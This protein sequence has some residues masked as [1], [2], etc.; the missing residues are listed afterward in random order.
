MPDKPVARLPL[1]AG[2]ALQQG[3]I[4][5]VTDR[6]GRLTWWNDEAA[7]AFGLGAEDALGMPF[8]VVCGG[9]TG[10]RPVDIDAVLDGRDFA[11]GIECSRRDGERM[12]LYAFATAGR[13]ERGEVAGVVFIARDVTGYWRAEEVLRTSEEKYRRLFEGSSDIVLV[14]DTTGRIEDANLAAIH[15]IGYTADEL[16]SLSLFEIVAPAGRRAAELALTQMRQRGS[17]MSVLTVLTRTGKNVTLETSTSI[18]RVGASQKV[19]VIGRD[20]T[21]RQLA[22]QRV[23][24]SEHKYRRIFEAS[25]DAIMLATFEMR[26]V[27]CNDRACEMFGRTQPELLALSI[28]DLVAHGQQDWL[29]LLNERLVRTGQYRGDVSMLGQQGPGG[30]VELTVDMTASLLDL[31]DGPVVL[32]VGHD[33]SERRRA[34]AALRESEARYRTLRDNVPIGLFRTT[35]DGRFISI[36]PA[37]VRIAGYRSEAEML[38]V[39]V[40]D[41]YADPAE[42]DRLLDRLARDGRVVDAQVRMRRPDGTVYDAQLNVEVTHSPDGAVQYFDGAIQDITE[43]KRIAAE[44]VD[45]EARLRLLLEQLPTVLWTVDENLV[46][47]TSMGAG[48]AKLGQAPGEVVGMTLYEYFGTD[49]PEFQPIAAHRQVLNGGSARY[50]L[51]WNGETFDTVLEPLRDTGGA[52]VGVIGLATDVTEERR[53]EAE[54][55]ASE[56]RYR[57][58]FES[59]TDSVAIAEVDGRV[60]DA[61]PACIKTYGYTAEEVRQMNLVDVVAPEMR[62]VAVRAMADLATGKP[63]S[64]TIP[65]VRKDGSRLTVDTLAFVGTVGG[66]RRIFSFTR[67]VSARIAAEAARHASEVRYRSLAENS[68][69][70][71]YIVDRGGVVR[72]CNSAG[73]AALGRP[74]EALVGRKVSELFP[75]T[76]AERQAGSLRKVFETGEPQHV[77]GPPRYDDREVWLSTWLVGL[78]DAAGNVTEV[79]GVSRDLTERKRAEDELRESEARYRAI[80]ETTAAAT[81]II[82]ADTTISLVNQEFTR[83]FGYAGEEVR[84]RSWTEFVAKED[85]ERLRS[86][87]ELR[88]SEDPVTAPRTYEARLVDKQGAVRQCLLTV[89]MVAGTGRSVA[90]ILDI[91]ERKRVEADLLDSE[92]RFRNLFQSVPVGLYRTTPDGRIL[93]A[94]PALV[95]MLG[96]DSWGELRSRSLE[97]GAFGPGENRAAFRAAVEGVDELIGW[98]SNWRRKDGSFIHVR[99]SARA[100]RDVSG[101]VQ[102][103]EGTAED[104]TA[105]RRAL[106]D[107]EESEYNFRALAENSGDGIGIT[108]GSSGRFV[109]VNERVSAI[110]G[111]D[112]AELLEMAFTDVV[113]PEVRRMMVERLKSRVAGGIEP[114]TYETTVLRKDGTPVAVELSVAVTTWHG[115]KATIAAVRDISERKAAAEALSRSEQDY[116]TALDAMPDAATVMDAELTIQVA[117]RAMRGWLEQ[118]GRSPEVVGR[119]L[120]EAFPFLGSSVEDEYRRVFESGEPLRTTETT[121]VGSEVI[122]TETT[123]TPIVEDGKVVR[124]LT[125]IHNVTEHR[126]GEQRLRES[127]ERYRRLV[128]LSPDIVAVHQAGRIVFANPA[129]ARALGYAEG[130]LAGKSI[131]EMLHPDDRPKVMSR[132]SRVLEDGEAAPPLVERFVRKDGSAIRVEARASAFLWRGRPAVLVVARKLDDVELLLRESE[133]RYRRL[134]DL[135]PSI[136]AVHQQGRVVFANNTAARRLGYGSPEEAVGLPVIEFVHPDDRA[137]AAGRIRSVLESGESAPPATERFVRRDGGVVRVEVR[138]S[139]FQWEGKPAV[140]VVARDL[141]DPVLLAHIAEGAAAGEGDVLD[142]APHGIA[143]VL[144]GLVVH[145]NRQFCELF[146]YAV[147]MELTGTGIEELLEPGGRPK[148]LERLAAAARG[149]VPGFEVVRTLTKSGQTEELEM[150]VV[151]YAGTGFKYS[152]WF[153]RRPG[154]GDGK[155]SVEPRKRRGRRPKSSN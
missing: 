31:A 49:N 88:R 105:T 62:E 90:S 75:A 148:A 119:K 86:Y 120:M 70:A 125:V 44:L 54:R 155:P 128:E 36:N 50:E 147:P 127:E 104:V 140:L 130:E 3:D 65:M 68:P 141:T 58:L 37:A 87:H 107:L 38:G 10:E 116:H 136:I 103:Y 102:Y 21:E 69:D 53:A 9:L 142:R 26:I 13:D 42:R 46:F 82:E 24:E 133:E 151:D 121:T 100:V 99:E 81:M 27:D 150:A 57:L 84:G 77:E 72:Y 117:N 20:I 63:V 47:T 66:E 115:E 114:R 64:L 32:C 61:N 146:G 51:E 92:R 91:T 52:V 97:N 106:A 135:S 5:F 16:R 152:L 19:L 137:F 48:L 153:A 85:L 134:V 80:F 22:E 33:V 23:R 112:R 79:L 123:R 126:R 17:T 12:A 154:E 8:D 1:D 76:I 109:Y 7:S 15:L 96:F 101:A 45:R 14:A 111:Y 149:T 118:L 110:T 30:R 89:D 67:D 43:S 73:S 139:P 71:I 35:P 98:E 131:M 108:Q 11:G 95:A 74:G 145:A 56:E 6:L 39:R 28:G 18:I 132:A 113:T 83:L 122:T 93:L 59:A 138:N 124:V 129:T 78:R 143:A 144:N 94:N 25:G 60:L 29:P 34:E 2:V 40:V 4:A 41:H 55:R